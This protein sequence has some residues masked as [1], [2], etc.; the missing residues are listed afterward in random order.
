MVVAREERFIVTWCRRER[1]GNVRGRW[2]RERRGDHWRGGALKYRALD[3]L[4]QRHPAR[5]RDSHGCSDARVI[6]VVVEEGSSRVEVS[7]LVVDPPGAL[8][9]AEPSTADLP[10]ITGGERHTVA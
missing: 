3:R 9:G 6:G 1:S 2:V 7:L 8:G 10:N 5:C 4:K